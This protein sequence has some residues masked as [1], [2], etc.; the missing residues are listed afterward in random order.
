M[1]DR[2]PVSLAL[3]LTQL[4]PAEREA[5]YERLQISPSLRAN[6]ETLL[7]AEAKRDGA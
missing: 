2:D 6:V 7:A 4:S 5:H 3:E 1:M